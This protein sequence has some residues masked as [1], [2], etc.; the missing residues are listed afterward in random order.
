MPET[1]WL[2]RGCSAGAL[3]PRGLGLES[4]ALDQQAAECVQVAAQDAQRQVAFQAEFASVAAVF[5]AVAGLQAA[6]GGLD[7]GMAF[8]GGSEGEV[9]GGGLFRELCGG[10]LEARFRKAG[11]RH[12]LGEFDLVLWRMEAAI[13]RQFL[14][15]MAKALLSS[16]CFRDRHVAVGFGA[17]E[18]AM[19]REES[20]AV[21]KHQHPAAE[22]HRL[23]GLASFVELRV[24]LANRSA[25]EPSPAVRSTR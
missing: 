12:Q 10:L 2:S 7:A 21:L 16:L 9:R 6:D 8:L 22:W 4:F 13:E 5:L 19:L 15:L 14:D 18:Q 1:V 25:H 23:A 17:T 11:G 20:R 24:W 3:G